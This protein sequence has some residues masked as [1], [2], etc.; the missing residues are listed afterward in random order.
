MSGLDV[1]VV[2]HISL[3]WMCRHRDAVDVLH[4]HWLELF[5]TYPS[6]RRS[7]KRWLSV[8]LAL[9]LARL[10]KVCII[11][12]VHNVW[13]HEG[14]RQCLVSWGNRVMLA[15]AH[16]VHVHNP[17]TA[18]ILRSR[19]GRQRDVRVIPHGSYLSAYPNTCTR[20]EAREALSVQGQR[21]V[22][23]F[24]GRVRPYKGVEALIRAFRRL[25]D[26]DAILLMAGKAEERAYAERI[27]VLAGETDG[28]RLHLH[29]VAEEKLQYYFGAADV[30]VL[31][32]RHVTTSG[33]AILSFSFGTP[34]VAPRLGS[35]EGLVGD[36]ERGIL[37]EP[38]KRDSLRC[39]LQ[40]IREGDLEAM[41][42]RCTRWAQEHDWT[43]IAHQH[44]EMYREVCPRTRVV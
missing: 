3:G 39:A 44:A 33:A 30:C 11:Y 19:W 2:D 17:E 27:R 4:I 29:F 37:Y 40:R 34:V 25:E 35:F 18:S 38:E 12:T 20:Q 28:V 21:F 42:Q 36:R 22:Y 15:L 24:L 26:E 1:A 8:M 5:F 6:W 7:V 10:S 9:C 13:Q 31:P 32:Y 41:G 43:T 14:R 23:L 16:G